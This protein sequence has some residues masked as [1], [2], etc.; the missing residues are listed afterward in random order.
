MSDDATIKIQ[1]FHHRRFLKFHVDRQSTVF[2]EGF[3]EETLQTLY[4]LLPYQHAET[5]RWYQKEAKDRGL[6]RSA[7]I[8]RWRMSARYG[9]MED[10]KF[11]RERLTLLKEAYDQSEP[12]TVSRFWLDKRSPVQWA[13]FWVAVLV[14]VLTIFFGLVQSIKGALQV[15]KAYHPLT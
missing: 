6:D 9:K 5:R 3:I 12:D 14:L 15:Y 7:C 11:W 10:F 8:R 2:P 1:I 4:L 13:K